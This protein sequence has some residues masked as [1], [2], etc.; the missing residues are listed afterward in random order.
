MKGLACLLANGSDAFTE[1]LLLELSEHFFRVRL[2]LKENEI[3]KAE[4]LLVDLDYISP[5]L[6]PVS[7][8]QRLIGYTRAQGLVYPFPVLHRP[9]PM[10]SLRRLIDGSE[11]ILLLHPDGDFR[12]VFVMGEAVSLTEREA[13]ILRLLW[14]A[15]GNPVERS[16]LMEEVFPSAET[17][18]SS[19]NVYI[20]YLRK[21]IERSHKRLIHSHRGGGYSLLIE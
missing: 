8:G 17:P 11:G 20:H 7:E 1:A 12:T 21:K 5:S 6:P 18:E 19:L 10:E 13:A 3:P 16:R 4:L 14:L 9:F 2:L 15:E